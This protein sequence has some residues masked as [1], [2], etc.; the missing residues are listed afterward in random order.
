MGVIVGNRPISQ[1]WDMNP[2]AAPAI[3]PDLPAMGKVDMF[4]LLWQLEEIRRQLAQS[5]RDYFWETAK[6]ESSREKSARAAEV[7]T[8]RGALAKVL[9]LM[10]AALQGTSGA[11]GFGDPEEWEQMSK[12][13]GALANVSESIKRLDDQSEA[14]DRTE[15]SSVAQLCGELRRMAEEAKKRGMQEIAEALNQLLKIMQDRGHLVDQI[16]R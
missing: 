9:T 7:A 2:D 14:G 15:A 3:D 16:A 6:L 5:E 11:C 13:F 8:Y 10:T 1:P 12:A 4:D